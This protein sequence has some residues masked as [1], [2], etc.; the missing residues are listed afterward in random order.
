MTRQLAARIPFQGDPSLGDVEATNAFRRPL[1]SNVPEK[2]VEH[3]A[4]E[5]RTERAEFPELPILQ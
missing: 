4:Q 1:I 2:K 3:V 5:A